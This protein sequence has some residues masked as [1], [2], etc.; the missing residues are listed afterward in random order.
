MTCGARRGEG[1]GPA[2][3]RLYYSSVTLAMFRSIIPHRAWFAGPR[4]D[5]RNDTEECRRVHVTILALRVLIVT[6]TNRA[7]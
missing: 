6:L 2:L 4:V 5:D 1:Q 3:I 7:R